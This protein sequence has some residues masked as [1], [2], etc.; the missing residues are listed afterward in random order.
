MPTRLEQD[1]SFNSAC[2]IAKLAGRMSLHHLTTVAE[3][4]PSD[5]TAPT[6]S[7]ESEGRRANTRPWQA[8]VGQFKSIRLLAIEQSCDFFHR[9]HIIGHARLHGWGDPERLVKPGV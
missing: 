5:K 1:K 6:T 4:L 2:N 9:P 8:V 3:W 7:V